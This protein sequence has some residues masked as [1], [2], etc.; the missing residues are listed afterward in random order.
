MSLH[1]WGHQGPCKASLPSHSTVRGAELPQAKKVLH[2]CV[3][4]C[5][6]CV[7]LFATLW[8]V[9]YQASLSGMGFSR[10][11]CWS[12]LANTGCHTLLEHC[13][14]CCPSR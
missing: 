5:F 4:G 13:I 6:G 7:R 3:Q 8:T 10:Q 9:G 11:E 14:S 2:L 12:I 1:T